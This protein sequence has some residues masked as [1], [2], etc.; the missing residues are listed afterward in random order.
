MLVAGWLLL[1]AAPAHE[2]L[3]VP[4]IPPT[5][6]PAYVSA[7]IPDDNIRGPAEAEAS[8]VRLAPSLFRHEK[9]FTPGLGYTPGSS[10]KESEKERAIKPSPGLDVRVRLP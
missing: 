9:N 1:G 6:H 3:P 8:S 2:D 10:F 7:P 4:P 5:E